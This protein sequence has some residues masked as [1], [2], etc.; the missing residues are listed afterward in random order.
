MKKTALALTL[1][2]GLFMVACG[3]DS[4]TVTQADQGGSQPFV[5]PVEEPLAAPETDGGTCLDMNAASDAR[6]AVDVHQGLILEAWE[7]GDVQQTAHYIDLVGED[8]WVI[9]LALK[10]SP[11]GF[12]LADSASYGYDA[13]S[14]AMIQ[15][16]IQFDSGDQA[17]GDALVEDANISIAEGD[18]A[19]VALTDEVANGDLDGAPMCEPVIDAGAFKATPGE[20]DLT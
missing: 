16:V 2:A 20:I 11:E 7:A 3:S 12:H 6:A 9:R 15:A 18:A 17:A 5:P 13:G 14:L 4:S 1:T 19:N 8:F 10:A